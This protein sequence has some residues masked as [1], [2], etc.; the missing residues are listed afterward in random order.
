MHASNRL[1]AHVLHAWP[2][3]NLQSKAGSLTLRFVDP[4]VPPL[5]PLELS[6]L[7]WAQ[8]ALVVVV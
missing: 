2:K 7:L 6:F 4:K 5:L 1:A 8:L 3:L